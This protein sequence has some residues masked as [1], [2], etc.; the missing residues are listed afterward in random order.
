LVVGAMQR[1]SALDWQALAALGALNVSD[2][3]SLPL[4]GAGT[5]FTPGEGS[6]C[7]L[8]ERADPGDTA[9]FAELAGGAFVSAADPLPHASG[10]H[11]ARAMQA[12]LAD[13]QLAMEDIDLI[14]AHATGT[15][16]GD[17]VELD[18]IAAL[19]DKPEKP[20]WLST[21]KSIAGH[22]LG[23]SGVVGLLAAVL[24]LRE[25]RVY[26]VAEGETRLPPG[27]RFA[28]GRSIDVLL[29]SAMVN[30][31]GFGG[32]NAALVVRNLSTN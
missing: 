23:A 9:G 2:E 6:A 20:V 25:Q 31:F 19:C 29:R 12:A 15:E 32:F 8:L 21:P 13:A 7:I 3:P 5:G 1:M 22:C 17:R 24:M 27:A 30:A 11:E 14:V 16:Q 4:F 10:E 26:P 18:A 28:Q